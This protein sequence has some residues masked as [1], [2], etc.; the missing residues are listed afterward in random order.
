MPLEVRLRLGQEVICFEDTIAVE[1]D[2]IPE[3][4][5]WSSNKLAPCQSIGDAGISGGNKG[6]RGGNTRG[7]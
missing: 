3:A 2:S 5:R 6:R 4:F 7:T 1:V